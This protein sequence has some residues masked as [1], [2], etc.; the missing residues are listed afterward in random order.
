MPYHEV[1]WGSLR[2]EETESVVLP[3]DFAAAQKLQLRIVERLERDGIPNKEGFWLRLGLEEGL[4]NAI[5]H[6]NLEDFNPLRDA[7][8]HFRERTVKVEYALGATDPFTIE[9][10]CPE[11]DGVRILR[12][13]ACSR[14]FRICIHDQGKGFDP[15]KLADCR[16]KENLEKPSGRGLLLMRTAFDH[17]DHEDSG[18]R[19]MLAIAYARNRVCTMT[20][21]VAHTIVRV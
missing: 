2:D 3:T 9:R 19:L 5:K 15:Q 1:L 13:E 7:P 12:K 8:S 14:V 6:G 21:E 20:P 18:R 10:E 4:V 17:V 11:N 16:A